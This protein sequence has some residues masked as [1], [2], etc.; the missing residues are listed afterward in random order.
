[1]SKYECLESEINRLEVHIK[2]LQTKQG[3]L[4]ERLRGAKA[5]DYIK[6]HNIT[7]DDIEMSEGDNKPYF[8][9]V[10]QFIEWVKECNSSKR[11]ME[12]NT[13]IHLTSDMLAGRFTSLDIRVADLLQKA[14][15]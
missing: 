4:Q 7:A 9:V 14:Q 8:R 3:V 12:W 11:Y 6:E 13:Q 2:E 1:M 5:Q 10:R 15:P